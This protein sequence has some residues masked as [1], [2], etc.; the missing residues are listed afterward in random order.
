MLQ[1]YF[2]G[3][4]ENYWGAFRSSPLQKMACLLTVL[5][6][7]SSLAFEVRHR[8]EWSRTLFLIG[9]IA[10]GASLLG[11]CLANFPHYVPPTCRAPSPV[12]WMDPA[13]A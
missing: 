4:V 12:W 1:V 9:W 3:F 7:L 10:V 5:C 11:Q 2:D 6:L 13:F 8:P